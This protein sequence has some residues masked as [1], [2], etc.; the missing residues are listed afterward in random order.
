MQRRRSCRRESGRHNVGVRISA[1]VDYA[2]RALV[3]LAAAGNVRPVTAERLADAQGIPQKFLQNI[4]LELRRAG[5]VASHRGPEGGHA[6]A[7][8]ADKITVADVI[9]AVDGPLGSVAGH[10]PEDMEYQGST[11]RLR[12]TWVA[13]RASVRG[14]LEGIT[15]ADIASDHLPD[16]IGK[17]LDGNDAWV[18]R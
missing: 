16:S 7:R 9:R 5:I 18:R 15:L 11:M 1:K 3:E 13:V 17:L 6:L 8:A 10:A 14:V 2:M 4:L 12:D